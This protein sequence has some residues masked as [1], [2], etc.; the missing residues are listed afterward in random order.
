MADAGTIQPNFNGFIRHRDFLAE[1]RRQNHG[2]PPE[3]EDEMPEETP[4]EEKEITPELILVED[5]NFPWNTEVHPANDFLWSILNDTQKADV[6]KDSRYRQEPSSLQGMVK[7]STASKDNGR[8]AT[9][10]SS[11][12]SRSGLNT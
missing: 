8:G 11:S 4:V 3:T 9:R 5:T 1:H 2:D 10:D 12:R 6:L 7:E